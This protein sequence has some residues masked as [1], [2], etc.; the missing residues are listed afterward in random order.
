MS[1]DEGRDRSN[2]DP[3]SKLSSSPSTPIPHLSLSSKSNNNNNSS[4]SRSPPA[5]S[6]SPSDTSL[7]ASL[8]S[9]RRGLF[10]LDRTESERGLTR[11]VSAFALSTGAETPQK[12]GSISTIS[13]GTGKNIAREALAAAE[14]SER[15]IELVFEELLVRCCF[16]CNVLTD[17]CCRKV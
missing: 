15:A 16:S 1:G 17:Y 12:R 2:S 10:P 4:E 5:L 3:S 13:G 14:Q 7:L 6:S 8:V 11:R 9:P